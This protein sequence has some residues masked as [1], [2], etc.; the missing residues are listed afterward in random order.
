LTNYRLS[1][2]VSTLKALF[3]V[4]ENGEK[5]I[6][7]ARGRVRSGSD[8]T[9][10]FLDPD[11]VLVGFGIFHLSL[12]VQKLFDF[13]DLR[14]KCPLK[15]LGR[16]IPLE[17]SFSSIRPLKGTSLSQTASFEHFFSPEN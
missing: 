17:K 11:L 3:L 7:A 15:M 8:V 6:S 14:A 12:A 1:S 4:A 5:T 9:I 10:R 2:T 16:D 13:F